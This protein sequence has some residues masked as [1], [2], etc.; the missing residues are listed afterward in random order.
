MESDSIRFVSSETIALD[1]NILNLTGPSWDSEGVTWESSRDGQLGTGSPTVSLSTGTHVITASKERL[2]RS[3][4]V[5]VFADLWS[6]YQAPPAQA[7]INRILSD[8]TFQWLD[9]ATGGPSQQWASYPGFPFDQTSPDPS[10][11]AV[12]C[13]LDALRHQGFLQPLPFGTAQT[14][15]EQL[16]LHTHTLRVSLGTEFNVAGGG[17]INLNR[18]FTLW[19]NNPAQPTV[20]TPY[21]HS[22]YLL[23]HESRHNEP[24]DPFHTSCTAWTGAAG[25]PNGMDAQLEPG[26]G[27]ARAALYLMWVYKYGRYDSASIRTEAK[28]IAVT[29]AD[30][31]CSRPT[32]VNAAVQAL[33]AELWNA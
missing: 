30:R 21:V 9:G 17:V 2:R 12:I 8:F 22:L 19:S 10:R 26:S 6:L 3:V 23:N 4:D 33:L 27:Y 24:G 5:R 25:V 14:A 7:E 16:R 11:T 32:S 18:T 13:K 1:A 20:V 31:F 15:Y 28:D 29:L